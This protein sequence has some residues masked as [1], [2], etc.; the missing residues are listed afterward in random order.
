[1]KFSN[2]FEKLTKSVHIGISSL[3]VVAIVAT[4]ICLTTAPVSAAGIVAPTKVYDFQYDEATVMDASFSIVAEEGN[5]SN[6]VLQLN[7]NGGNLASPN[8]FAVAP[9]SDGT[10]YYE[11]TAGSQYVF[12]VD[13]LV[14]VSNS[15]T[16]FNLAM[17]GV[18]INGNSIDSSEQKGSLQDVSYNSN[19]TVQKLKWVQYAG[20]SNYP[21]G[22]WFTVTGFFDTPG[23]MAGFSNFALM[24]E[25]SDA[26][27]SKFTPCFD[28]LKITKLD[29]SLSTIILD[30]QNEN[31]DVYVLQ[32][33]PGTTA[34]LPSYENAGCIN[35]GNYYYATGEPNG[36]TGTESYGALDTSVTN[37]FS[38]NFPAGGTGKESNKVKIICTSWFDMSN[39]SD[40]EANTT[41]FT[42]ENY[43]D[44][45]TSDKTAFSNAD[46]KRSNTVA[47]DGS[48]S[49]QFNG[50]AA[51]ARDTTNW[52][53]N[54]AYLSNSA[55]GA[56]Y[57]VKKDK[58][59]AFS[60]YW[61]ADNDSKYSEVQ[62]SFV[63]AD[64]TSAAGQSADG[65][66]W[67]DISQF[68]TRGALYDT[69]GYNTLYKDNVN[70]LEV[71]N[72]YLYESKGNWNLCTGYFSTGNNTLKDGKNNLAIQFT[73]NSNQAVGNAVLYI[74]NVTVT[75]LNPEESTVLY[76]SQNADRDFKLMNSIAGAPL[77]L[78][79]N[80]Q[81]T[82][83]TQ[84]T[85]ANET[86][87]P[88]VD[89]VYPDSDFTIIYSTKSTV[90]GDVNG[91]WSLDTKDIIRAKKYS[92]GNGKTN[93]VFNL[94]NLDTENGKINAADIAEIC[95]KLLA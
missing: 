20:I 74:D 87:T 79:T 56:L 40:L 8:T 43:P 68:T 65:V 73:M 71:S 34:T 5:S 95:K 90:E 37:K 78:P 49:L 66:A 2:L 94:T 70:K 93:I 88:F 23:D 75:E 30:T 60:F 83:Y 81:S 41:A 86:K 33:T 28:N 21:K 25:S 24:I 19:L 53:P 57:Q 58:K 15:N 91:D 39:I 47:Y 7:G 82:Y 32:G 9:L 42:F 80:G 35:R 11:L 6:K 63:G 77:T 4:G 46:S 31:G 62:F 61:Y 48:Y 18:K 12:S 84:S 55:D 45:A 26:D 52:K 10:G 50:D 29:V 92:G 54:F 67:S 27:Q 14:P 89:M 22:T 36:S 59:Y 17:R 72:F 1:M 76:V 51:T 44:K 69:S 3:C 13:I 16:S 64:G 38:G 85:S